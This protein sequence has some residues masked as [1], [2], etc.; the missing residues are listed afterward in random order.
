MKIATVFIVTMLCFI[1]LSIGNASK[2]TG[3]FQ[4]TPTSHFHTE[5]I[6]SDNLGQLKNFLTI[7]E[8]IRYIEFAPNRLF[9]SLGTSVVYVDT[10]DFMIEQLFTLDLEKHEVISSL[11]VSPDG[12]YVAV[13]TALDKWI[14]IDAG[15]GSKVEVV[16]QQNFDG[17]IILWDT[18]SHN[19]TIV[20]NGSTVLGLDFSISNLLAF[21][22]TQGKGIYDPK[23]KSLVVE[24][25]RG[26]LPYVVFSPDGRFLAFGTNENL[27]LYD[28]ET[29]EQAVILRDRYQLGMNFT[30]SPDSKLLI[31]LEGDAM[32]VY[33]IGNRQ[34]THVDNEKM[35]MF[36]PTFQ[37]SSNLLAL[38]GGEYIT[39]WDL[40]TLSGHEVICCYSQQ[41]LICD[42]AFHPSE[43][44]L[45][46]IHSNGEATFWDSITWSMLTKINTGTRCRDIYFSPDG[47]FIIFVTEQ[48]QI[49]IWGIESSELK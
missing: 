28:T 33:D 16:T 6:N 26:F 9:V 15:D 36:V 23:N 31:N 29:T 25:P 46:I 21:S 32:D 13:G 47:R 10:N 48:L 24:F 20:Q 8:Q 45:A 34:A 49:Q 43:N 42:M 7:E 41:N 22:T 44:I 12:Q 11:A 4:P 27:N 30:L 39:I 40:D 17:K 38:T 2:S 35:D 1:Y 37:P 5:V 19:T 18:L 3:N 14:T